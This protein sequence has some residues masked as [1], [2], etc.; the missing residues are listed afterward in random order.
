MVVILFFVRVYESPDPDKEILQVS[1][2]L[3][4]QLKSLN[5]VFVVTLTLQ[6]ASPEYFGIK[7]N[8]VVGVADKIFRGV[9]EEHTNQAEIYEAEGN[10]F[11]DTLNSAP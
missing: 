9:V 4:V 7:I 5:V 11:P 2:L 10:P 1:L 8:T 3:Y 6:T